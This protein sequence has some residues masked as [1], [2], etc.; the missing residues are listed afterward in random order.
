MIKK[1]KNEILK[2]GITKW[3]TKKMNKNTEE[4]G[5]NRIK[6]G[7]KTGIENRKIKF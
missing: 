2:N 7:R 3:D 1:Q 4:M 6:H 5:N